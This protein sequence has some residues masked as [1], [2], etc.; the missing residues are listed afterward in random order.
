MYVKDIVEIHQKQ[1][2]LACKDD[3]TFFLRHIGELA[4][5]HPVAA[6][7]FGSVEV[8]TVQ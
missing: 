6:T 5:C 4:G 7:C 8:F 1:V 3:V 2:L